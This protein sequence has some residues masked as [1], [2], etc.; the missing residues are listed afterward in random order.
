MLSHD[1]ALPQEV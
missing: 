1:D